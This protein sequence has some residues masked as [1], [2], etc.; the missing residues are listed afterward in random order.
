MESAI[1]DSVVIAEGFCTMLLVDASLNQRWLDALQDSKS[2]TDARGFLNEF[3]QAEGYATS[4]DDVLIYATRPVDS[5]SLPTPE[6]TSFALQLTTD[7]RLRSEW[8]Q[9]MNMLAEAPDETPDLQ[10]VTEFLKNNHVNA[11][12]V[13]VARS[14]ATQMN[15]GVALWVGTYGNT[16]ISQGGKQ[17]SGPTLIV[18][19]SSISLDTHKIV[20][21]SFDASR[22]TLSWTTDMNDTAGN[23]V[24]S[25]RTSITDD[26]PYVGNEFTGTLTLPSNTTYALHGTVEFSGRLGEAKTTPPTVSTDDLESIQKTSLIVASL[27]GSV[28]LITAF[29]KF[30]GPLNSLRIKIRDAYRKL[31]GQQPEEEYARTLAEDFSL[32]ELQYCLGLSKIS[33]IEKLRQD[34]VSLSAGEQLSEKG[35]E[36]LTKIDEVVSSISKEQREILRERKDDLKSDLEELLEE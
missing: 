18:Q 5:E 27:V 12:P 30:R 28:T 19:S 15:D 13:E 17:V 21:A 3:L 25:R 14:L 23:I 4:I 2:S 24:F 20:N 32:E 8:S 9:L 34:Y 10:P 35:R 31:R 11:T 22:A 7:G 1:Q 36:L 29:W 6:S 33:R 16:N 26:D